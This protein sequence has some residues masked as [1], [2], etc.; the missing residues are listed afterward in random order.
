MSKTTAIK[1]R[2]KH[3]E[4]KL[5]GIRK[6]LRHDRRHDLNYLPPPFVIELGGS[7]DSGKTTIIEKLY[8]VLH[9]N[10]F[11]VSTPQEGA[12]ATQHISR[13]TPMYNYYTGVYTLKHLLD[14]I[15]TH[16]FDVII[17]DRGIFDIPTWMEYWRDK[18]AITESERDIATEFFLSPLWTRH[19]TASYYFIT[20][21][22]TAVARD[23]KHS[24]TDKLGAYT[25]PESIRRRVEHYRK[26]YARIAERFPQLELVDTS[27]MSLTEMVDLMTEKV[28]A[29]I[30]RQIA[31]Q[32]STQRS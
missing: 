24:S 31:A 20:D 25:N 30:E 7:P 6:Y 12:Q 15:N 13:A 16:T 4:Q 23:L 26:V 2:Q 10:N 18:D 19:I 11:R 28:L 29:A 32:R 14:A 5:A 22:E 8:Q 17:L 21:P 9:R 27:E 3:F 1:L